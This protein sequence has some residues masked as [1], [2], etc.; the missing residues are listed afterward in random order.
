MPDAWGWMVIFSRLR[1]AGQWLRFGQITETVKAV[2]G[3]VASEIEYRG[4]FG[5][6]VGYWAYGH[7]D[8]SLPYQG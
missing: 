7:F 6:V 2:D 1:A 3:G 4:R 8:P 5:W